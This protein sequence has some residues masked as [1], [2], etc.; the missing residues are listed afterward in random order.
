ML[1]KI[2][3]AFCKIQDKKY[4]LGKLIYICIQTTLQVTCLVTMDHIDLSQFVYHR[5]NLGQ[6]GNSGCLVRSVT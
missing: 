4:K 2:W 3:K 6:H 5:E 1:S